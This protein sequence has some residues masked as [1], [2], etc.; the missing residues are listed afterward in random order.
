MA[1]AS[2]SLNAPMCYNHPE[3][4]ADFKCF[5]CKYD[6]IICLCPQCNIQVHSLDVFKAHRYE[7][8]EVLGK[9]RRLSQD[10]QDI[11][12][13][14]EVENELLQSVLTRL[15]YTEE[16]EKQTLNQL[17]QMQLATKRR[18]AEIK[19]CTGAVE[20]A[21]QYLAKVSNMLIQCS[22]PDK[23]SSSELDQAVADTN[24]TVTIKQP[25]SSESD[26]F[27][28]PTS[29]PAQDT[30]PG[31]EEQEVPEEPKVQ[32]SKEMEGKE[33]FPVSVIGSLARNGSFWI[34]KTGEPAIEMRKEIVM[35]INNHYKK[36]GFGNPVV[37]KVGTFCAALNRQSKEFCRTRVESVPSSEKCKIRFLDYG[38]VEESVPSFLCELSSDLDE[39]F[40][41]YQAF[42][43][44]LLSN[45]D[46]QLPYEAKWCFKD[47]T[48]SRELMAAVQGQ[49]IDKKGTVIYHLLLS[50]CGDNAVCINSKVAQLVEE[51]KLATEDH[52]AQPR[53]A[54]ANAEEPVVQKDASE[55]QTQDT[56]GTCNLAQ[57]VDSEHAVSFGE[58]VAKTDT[59]HSVSDEKVTGKD[60]ISVNAEIIGSKQTLRPDAEEFVPLSPERD[61]VLDKISSLPAS[62][63]ARIPGILHLPGQDSFAKALFMSESKVDNVPSSDHLPNDMPA[64]ELQTKDVLVHDHQ[65]NQMSGLKD[66]AENMPTSESQTQNEPTSEYSVEGVA[67]KVQTEQKVTDVPAYELLVK[68]GSTFQHL[69]SEAPTLGPEVN[70]VF[71]IEHYRNA[72]PDNHLSVGVV[73]VAMYNY[74][75]NKCSVS[76]ICMEELPYARFVLIKSDPRRIIEAMKF[77]IWCSNTRTNRMLNLALNS[78]RNGGRGSVFLLFAGHKFIK[79][80]GLAE[81]LTSVDPTQSCPMLNEPFKFGGK[82]VGRC[83]IRWIYANSLYFKDIKFRPES[84]VSVGYFTE[85]MDGCEIANDVGRSIVKA[86][87]SI[88]YFNSI[89]QDAINTRQS[90]IDNQKEK[91]LRSDAELP[92][93]KIAK[94]E[95]SDDS[96]A[97]QEDWDQEMEDSLKTSEGPGTGNDKT[98][99]SGE[100]NSDDCENLSVDSTNVSSDGPGHSDQGADQIESDKE[101]VINE[102]DS[103]RPNATVME[104]LESSD[105]NRIKIEKDTISADKEPDG[106][107]K[108]VDIAVV[109]DITSQPLNSEEEIP[110]E[111]RDPL[112]ENNS[113]APFTSSDK[114]N[115]SSSPISPAGATAEVPGD[116]HDRECRML[117][118]ASPEETETVPSSDGNDCEVRTPSKSSLEEAAIVP[119]NDGSDWE[120]RTPSKTSLEGDKTVPSNDGSDWEARTPSQTSLEG[121]ETVPSNDGSDWEVRTPSKTSLQRDV[122]G[123]TN[124]SSSLSKTTIETDTVAKS[125]DIR[126]LETSSKTG[127]RVNTVTPLCATSDLEAGIPDKSLPQEQRGVV[128][129]MS[130]TSL[131]EEFASQFIGGSDWETGTPSKTSLVEGT[132]IGPSG[133]SDWETRTPS[134]TSLDT[135]LSAQLPPL[136]DRNTENL[137][138]NSL[139][140]EM[141]EYP[142]DLSD[143]EPGEPSNSRLIQTTSVAD[144]RSDDIPAIAGLANSESC[145][146]VSSSCLLSPEL[147]SQ[148]STEELVISDYVPL[149]I[150]KEHSI[151]VQENLTNSGTFWAKIT[152]ARKEEDAFVDAMVRMGT[153]IEASNKTLDPSEIF[154]YKQCAVK[155]RDEYWYRAL[156]EKTLDK[157]KICIRLLDIGDVWEVNQRDLRVLDDKFYTS[158]PAQAFECCIVYSNSANKKEKTR[159]AKLVRRNKKIRVLVKGYS[160]G[161][162]EVQVLS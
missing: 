101:V 140:T 49:V 84:R 41:P 147:L 95:L 66:Q 74:I 2:L 76:M 39:K 13:L 50:T 151:I 113:R 155:G 97:S 123:P 99:I 29:V 94:E 106:N 153:H 63:Q 98:E 9:Q 10:V 119:S 145:R 52:P 109:N 28:Q 34:S 27:Q 18:V 86:Y 114:E 55:V 143:L 154:I 32:L 12:K 144:G 91:Q 150:G 71:S 33:V 105:P 4:R 127:E 23:E 131:D 146:E 122:G 89:L 31:N 16:E 73:D 81:M 125:T 35:A 148:E 44:C 48:F 132:A 38:F 116:A 15:K 149:E 42:Q 108:N 158:P 128:P 100:V 80:C 72:V 36:H 139:K 136:S 120:V 79:F 7:Q 117:S 107:I 162:V 85:A 24:A 14:L 8:I 138:K 65:G 57:E 64:S 77:D 78:V 25:D 30:L 45:L 110:M 124:A 11:E 130:T 83:D 68:K 152:R 1:A 115:R 21:F 160:A 70:E 5:D 142:G 17:V 103:R 112:T 54:K 129:T 26:S 90:N 104:R 92:W 133:E 53:E 156:V 161:T 19:G 62:K 87:E 93:W 58:T 60:K 159:I 157:G 56:G 46:T 37:P 20:K 126:P 69:G 47:L 40:I 134:K 59:E 135:D 51:Q 82:M 22:T 43:A 102:Y 96:P 67:K 61:K 111:K 141:A 75:L 118:K 88:T 121:V 3:K 6:R 137:L